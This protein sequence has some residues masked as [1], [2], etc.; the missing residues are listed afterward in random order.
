MTLQAE[1]TSID[2]EI[3]NELIELTPDWWDSAVLEVTYSSEQGVETYSHEIS[4]PE[5]HKD[6]VFPSEMLF[7][8]THR[9]SMLFQRYG[10]RWHKAIFEVQ[11]QEDR[12]WKYT[13]RFE[14]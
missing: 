9:L 2:Q 3:A 4:S 5:K 14:Y 8:A 7:D 12:S 10:R 11:L 13:V 6:V 1:E